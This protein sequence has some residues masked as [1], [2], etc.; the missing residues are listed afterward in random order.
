MDKVKTERFPHSNRIVRTVDYKTIYKVG[1]KIHSERFV[2]FYRKNEIGHCRLGM[3]VSRKIGCAVIRNRTKRLFREIFR[4]T[5][6]EIP[7]NLDIIINAKS[8]CVSAG[9]NEL[10]EEFIA[11]AKKAAC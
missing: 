6:E 1:K 11:A 9:F 2:L 3:T 7:G 4:K 8:G 10:R 5:S